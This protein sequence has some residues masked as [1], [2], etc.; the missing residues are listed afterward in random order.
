MIQVLKDLRRGWGSLAEL[1][2]TRERHQELFNIAHCG[3][4]RPKHHLRLHLSKCLEIIYVDTWPTEARHQ[5]FKHQLAD[6]LQGL[7]GQGGGE[8]SA[9]VM[10]RML[11]RTVELQSNNWEPQ[12]SGQIY[13]ANEVSDLAGINASVST[14]FLHGT[15][16]LESNEILCWDGHRAGWTLFF[17]EEAGNFLVLVELLQEL[18]A[19]MPNVRRFVRTQQKKFLAPRFFGQSTPARVVE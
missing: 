4:T 7:L 14:K 16:E 2:A 3:H 9:Q 17:G 6:S 8:F 5:M 13:N 15:L 10:T 11:H 19:D 18:A 1:L 12:L